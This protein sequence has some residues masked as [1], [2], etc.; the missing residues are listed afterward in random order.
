[1]GGSIGGFLCSEGC[2]VGTPKN[3]PA[4]ICTGLYFRMYDLWSRVSDRGLL[5]QSGALLAHSNADIVTQ[6]LEILP[7]NLHFSTR[8]TRILMSI[9]IILPGTNRKYHGQNSSSLAKFQH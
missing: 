1:M 4:Y 6:I 3:A 2:I 8:R 9:T 5:V 7:R